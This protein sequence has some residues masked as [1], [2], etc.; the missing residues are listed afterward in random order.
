MHTFTFFFLFI[1]ITSCLQQ[2]QP[3]SRQQY[4]M[5]QNQGQLN[6][7]NPALQPPAP[8]P[9]P[10]TEPTPPLS[11]Q[12]AQQQAPVAKI[13]ASTLQIYIPSVANL[14]QPDGSFASFLKYD[15]SGETDYI[16]YKIC[17]LE[18]TGEICQEGATCT[19]NGACVENM[20]PQ[21]GL[22]LPNLYS[23]K[24]QIYLSACISPERAL[25][26]QTCGSEQDLI[27]DAQRPNVEVAKLLHQQAMYEKQ[28]SA[29]I[30]EHKEY[31]TS[32]VEQ[33]KMCQEQ[34][35]KVD[36]QLNRSVQIVEQF[37]KG[38]IEF[39]PKTIL[40]DDA[41]YE[42]FTEPITNWFSDFKDTIVQNC[43]ND[44]NK[45]ESQ[46]CQTWGVALGMVTGIAEGMVNPIPA[47]GY[48]VR[49][50]N[51][52]TNPADSIPLGCN[53]EKKLSTAHFQYESRKTL[54]VNNYKRVTTKLA[55]LKASPE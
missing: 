47:V 7:Q 19:N 48:M 5:Q 15:A 20:T 3:G 52:L 16:K 51:T 11:F 29:L 49:S 18:D 26:Q 14:Q 10:A 41:V 17:P 39:F 30:L 27:Y 9:L 2:N 54:L 23:G 28:A 44:S 22:T 12:A 1:L 35:A 25:S 50:I 38:P 43:K 37:I 24:I 36:A 46:D 34:N 55:E 33:G 42:N 40:M 21:L 31:L 53:Q 45:E 13:D 6:Q 8:Q 32:W 4:G